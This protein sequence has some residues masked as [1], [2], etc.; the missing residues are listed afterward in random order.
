MAQ[1]Y[2]S[3]G[4]LGSA[5]AELERLLAADT[6]DTRLLQQLSKLAEEEG[7]LESAARYQKQQNELAPSDDGSSRLAQLYARGGEL[8]QAEAEWSKMASGKSDRHRI[9]GAMDS[10]LAQKKDGPV[11]E[12]TDSMVRK[13]PHDWEA[14]YRLAI[15][16]VDQGKHDLAEERFRALLELTTA[17]DEL[18]ALGPCPQQG[19][20]ADAGEHMPSS[21]RQ[22]T[23]QPIEQR[24]TQVTMIR[25]ATMLD[26]RI[27]VSS[28]A[29]P[30]VWM[31]ADF[32]QA[33]MASLAW[34]VAIAE[35]HNKAQAEELIARIRKAGEKSPADPRAL[36]DSF[37]LSL[38]RF[39]N[40][41]TLAAG[42]LLSQGLPND[43]LALWAYLYSLG[44]REQP[45][46]QR[47]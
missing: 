39:D 36:W 17:D 40:A 18:S 32:G 41:G 42:K 23:G 35:R 5:R 22:A 30:T 45:T 6:R 2:A 34:L 21:T 31:P 20:Q 38:V 43:P 46:G 25:R 1:A 8:E 24:L 26:G 47:R 44:G 15:S 11:F 16:L 27:L 4:D 7:D 12:I 29:L 19:P 14:L 3:S 28:R 33:R 9:F 13:D 37:Y 10:L